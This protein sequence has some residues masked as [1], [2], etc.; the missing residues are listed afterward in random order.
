MA[1]KKKLRPKRIYC[2]YCNAPA[3][4]QRTDQ[5]YGVECDTMLYVCKNYPACDT[6]IRTIPGTMQP[7]GTMANA[8]LRQLRRETHE[9]F[10]QLYLRHL[11]TKDAAYDWMAFWL[12]CQ[13]SNA[14]IAMLDTFACKLVAQKSKEFLKNNAWKLDS[15]PDVK[16]D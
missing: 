7:L 16:A 2:P 12:S 13:R 10:D 15:I 6:Y 4:L 14:H 3:V 11:M 1:A 8:E 5:V 9:V